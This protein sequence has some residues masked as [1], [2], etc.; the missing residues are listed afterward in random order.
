[1]SDP[2]ADLAAIAERPIAGPSYTAW[3]A[4][5]LDLKTYMP[6]VAAQLNEGLP[7]AEL[8]ERGYIER[9]IEF[10]PWHQRDLGRKWFNLAMREGV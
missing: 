6:T 3:L 4:W 1:M 9:A 2:L 5:L 10:L 7:L 8:P